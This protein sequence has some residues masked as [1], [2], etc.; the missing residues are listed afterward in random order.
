[1]FQS[2]YLE[3]YILADIQK[4][5]VFIGGPRQVGKTTLAKHVGQS[6]YPE[7]TYLNWDNP[8]HRRNIMDQSFPRDSGLLIFDE[9][10]KYRLWKNYVKGIYDTYKDSLQILVTGSARLDVYRRGGD[11]LFG[12]YRYYRLHPFSLRELLEQPWNGTPLAE[13][14]FLPE[15]AVIDS[16]SNRLLEFG[17]FPEPFF[18]GDAQTLRRFHNERADRLIKEDIRDVERVSDVSLL[19]LLADM[20]PGKVGSLFSLQ[21]IAEDLSVT[22]KTIGRWVDIL[23]RFYYQYRIY[24]YTSKKIRSLKKQ[25]KLYLWDWSQVQ[26]PAARLENMVASHLLK[27]VH[28][29]YDFFGYK[30]DLFFLRDSDGREV[31]FLVTIDTKPWF[32]VEVKTRDAQI[33][34][35]ISYFGDRLRIP[36]QYQVVAEGLKDAYRHGG[37]QVMNLN[38]FLSGLA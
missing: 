20:L 31:D 8:E 3:S 1:M 9:I 25:P 35:N 36:F 11:S 37:V 27:T 7:R 23:E 13:L 19:Q 6:Q 4:K 5:M 26:D 28:L 33:S 12:R 24:P 29:L 34:P 15:S 18:A 22:H 14:P 30:A 2:R 17:G 38:H 10:H 32:S 16:Q 21:S